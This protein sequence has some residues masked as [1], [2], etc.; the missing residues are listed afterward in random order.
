VEYIPAGFYLVADSLAPMPHF[1]KAV[2]D[3]VERVTHIADASM[4]HGVAQLIGTPISQRGVVNYP[5]TQLG[6]CIGFTGADF[7]T[8][9]EVCPSDKSPPEKCLLAQVAAVMG[10]LDFAKGRSDALQV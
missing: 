5:T 1:Q 7:S 6:C 2:L 10:A 8:A 9:T 4:T 3:A